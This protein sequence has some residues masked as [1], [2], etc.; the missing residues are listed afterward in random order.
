VTLRSWSITVITFAVLILASYAHEITSGVPAYGWLHSHRP[1]YVAESID[2]IG[3]AA[4]CLLAVWLMYRNGIRG[5][6]SELG[7]SGPVLP[8][9]AFARIASSP[10]LI[11]FAITRSLT[12]HIEFLALLFLTVL[13]PFVEEIEFRG[14]GVRQLQRGTG[15]PF[16]VVVWPSALLFGYGH[17]EQGQSLQEMAGLFFLTGA[18]GVTFAWLVYR[19][20]NL[21]VAVALHICMNLWWELYSVAKTAI[22]GWFPFML[23]NL[24]MLLAIFITL[25]RTPS[26]VATV[27]SAP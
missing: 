21:W 11:G 7:L 18:G 1:F 13:S 8:A 22:G 25:Y 17:V 15:W 2:K 4:V 20:Q 26:K 23:Q 16:W 9:I 27:A 10:M 19:W 5:I 6:G 12:P 3:G 14:F 24:T